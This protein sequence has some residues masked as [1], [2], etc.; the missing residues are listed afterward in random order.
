MIV[1]VQLV[2]IPRHLATEIFRE[3]ASSLIMDFFILNY[4]SLFSVD[5]N[6]IILGKN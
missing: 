3:T 6:E 5:N 1:I 4:F 2:K